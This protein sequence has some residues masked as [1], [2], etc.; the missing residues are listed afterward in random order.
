MIFDLNEFQDKKIII[1]GSSTGIGFETAIEFLKL[2]ANVIFHGNKSMDDIEQRIKERTSKSS[3]S[4]L[5]ADFTKLSEVEKFME[6]SPA[7]AEK[8]TSGIHQENSLANG[9]NSP[10]PVTNSLEKAATNSLA[11]RKYSTENSSEIPL[12]KRFFIHSLKLFRL[13]SIYLSNSLIYLSIH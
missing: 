10:A 7:P 2:G 4:I 5:K 9:K 8:I 3:Y 11:L 6:N 13:I 1:T 12:K